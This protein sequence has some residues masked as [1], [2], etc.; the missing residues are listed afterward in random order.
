MCLSQASFVKIVFMW[1]E[2][3]V[4]ASTTIVMGGRCSGFLLD[5]TG[6]SGLSG[7]S[8]AETSSL[9]ACTAVNIVV[10]VACIVSME[11][12]KV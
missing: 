6:V 7:R 11:M 10:N 9:I 5:R 8:L 12:R 4:W 2:V 3:E 1:E